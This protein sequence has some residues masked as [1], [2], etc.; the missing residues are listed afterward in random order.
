MTLA[1]CLA[2]SWPCNNI[3]VCTM[4]G[5]LP[6]PVNEQKA[7]VYQSCLL[8]Q[9]SLTL[10][11]QYTY[12][13]FMQGLWRPL[14]NCVVVSRAP[15]SIVYNVLLMLQLALNLEAALKRKKGHTV[16]FCSPP[17]YIHSVKIGLY[18]SLFVTG[19]KINIEK[20]QILAFRLLHKKWNFCL[21]RAVVK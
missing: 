13:F 20:I 12:S 7:Q 1:Y 14:T 3:S 2:R 11:N 8:L 19:S 18:A 15:N 10:M 16:S 5:F 4:H 17:V 9:T 21:S 6:Q